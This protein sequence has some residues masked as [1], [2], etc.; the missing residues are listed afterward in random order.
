MQMLA[1]R[2]RLPDP[3]SGTANKH[4]L[5]AHSATALRMSERYTS[6][7]SPEPEWQRNSQDPSKAAVDGIVPYGC[8]HH[9][10]SLRR[11]GSVIEGKYAKT[12]I[13]LKEEELGTNSQIFHI[14][15][16]STKPSS[17]M[18]DVPI[19]QNGILGYTA[20]TRATGSDGAPSM[21]PNA[22]WS[23]DGGASERGRHEASQKDDED[24]YLDDGGDECDDDIGRPQ[25]A[26]ERIAARRKMKR[27]RCVMPPML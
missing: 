11:L 21:N 19:P 9:G 7:F 8:D 16:G 5:G 25:T 17:T 12:E 24:I 26:A 18:T 6:I 15:S 13:P 1:A 23:N 27:F 22:P 14:P 20:G 2:H 3:D 10:L 4:R